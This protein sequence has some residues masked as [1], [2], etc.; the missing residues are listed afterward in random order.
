MTTEFM[1]LHKPDSLQNSEIALSTRDL[2]SLTDAG[3]KVV[4]AKN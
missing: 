1:F 2:H 4:G 3:V